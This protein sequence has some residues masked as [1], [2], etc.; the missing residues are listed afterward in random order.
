MR[1]DVLVQGEALV[2]LVPATRGPLR[3]VRAFSVHPGGAPANVAVGLARLGAKVAFAGLVGDDEFGA[4]LHDA[5]AAEG[6]ELSA[7]QRTRAGKTGL[8][9]VEL[10]ERGERRFFGYGAPT[11]DSFFG[12]EHVPEALVRRCR[13]VHLGSN[14]LVSEAGVSAT[15]RLVELARDGGALVSVDPNL[16]LHLWRDVSA[17]RPRLRPLLAV[18]S[19]AKLSDEEAAFLY[20]PAEP[21][22]QA[23]RLVDDGLPLAVVTCGA[24]GAHWARRDGASGHVP[25]P[26]VEVVD[27]T[28]AG[29][30]FVAGLLAAL[31][32]ALAAGGVPAELPVPAWEAAV[33][34][35]C[36]VGAAV[37]RHEG[38]TAGL[39]RRGEPL[40]A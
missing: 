39:P 11:A 29:D 20:G 35:G 13:V 32:P 28:G 36:R 17:L 1:L 34:Y 37:V 31:A 40:P 27:A 14:G 5:L 22:R 26:R 18:A 12:P 23:R 3:S 7:L 25:S 9:F 16:R 10:D 33:L 2:D 38:A 15:R 21:A 6:I 24:G 30:G 19:L 8:S 4:L